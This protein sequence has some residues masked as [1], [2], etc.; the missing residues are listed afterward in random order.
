MKRRP[1]W[2]DCDARTSVYASSWSRQNSSS[3]PKKSWRGSWRRRPKP[4]RRRRDCGRADGIGA[5]DLDGVVALL[6]EGGTED[7][8]GAVDG[9]HHAPAAPHQRVG[10]AVAEG[11]ILCEIETDKA[12]L[13]VESP[14]SGTLLELFFGVGD[15]VPVLTNIAVI[16]DPGEY[17]SVAYRPRREPSTQRSTTDGRVR[18]LARTARNAGASRGCRERIAGRKTG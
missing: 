1:S 16:G 3:L 14:A 15:E 2:R 4:N 7:V 13:E 6:A 9:G 5:G 10:D 18:T 8:G 12:L 17:L 11:D